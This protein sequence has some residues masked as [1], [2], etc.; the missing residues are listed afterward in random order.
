MFNG[1]SNGKLFEEWTIDDKMIKRNER[2]MNRE[3]YILVK[4]F[5]NEKSSKV[6]VGENI[7]NFFKDVYSG[8]TYFVICSGK[9]IRDEMVFRYMP[10]K[11]VFLVNIK[12]P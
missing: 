11:K 10:N 4:I 12:C 7:L 3:Y 1:R 8:V 9:L 6:R 2:G 5:G